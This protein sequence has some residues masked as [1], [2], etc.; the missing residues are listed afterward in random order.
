MYSGVSGSR[1]AIS[2]GS[3]DASCRWVQQDKTGK[4]S[5]ILIPPQP[6]EPT[7]CWVKNAFWSLH[8]KRRQTC[9]LLFNAKGDIFCGFLRPRFFSLSDPLPIVP[10]VLSFFPLPSLPMTQRGVE[11]WD[12]R[13]IWFESQYSECDTW[14]ILASN[15]WLMVHP[16][17]PRFSQKKRN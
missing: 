12:D 2:K 1:S 14:E 9:Y 8:L 7:L 15:S 3:V 13:K 6:I 11:N 4:K 16:F 10:R 5:R 17:T